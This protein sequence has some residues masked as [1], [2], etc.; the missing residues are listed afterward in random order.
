MNLGVWEVE[1]PFFLPPSL[2][3]SSLPL[4]LSLSISL[5]VLLLVELITS[6]QMF[7]FCLLSAS[8]TGPRESENAAM[9]LML[10][11]PSLVPAQ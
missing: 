1:N 6:A 10:S 5:P 3:S 2:F 9:S 8:P 11:I 4:F 7:H